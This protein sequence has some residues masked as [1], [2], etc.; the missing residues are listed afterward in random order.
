MDGRSAELTAYVVAI[1][2]LVVGGALLRTVIL[3]WFVGPMTVVLA[4]AFLTP[5][6]ERR[7]RR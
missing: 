6:L 4:V 2:V 7:R 3:N 5:L 1:A